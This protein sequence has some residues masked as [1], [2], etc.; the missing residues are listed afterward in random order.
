MSP[1]RGARAVG[2]AV[3][4]Q[5]RCPVCGRLRRLLSLTGKLARHAT[6]PG[7]PVCDGSYQ[8]PARVDRRGEA[9]TGGTVVGFRPGD[10]GPSAVGDPGESV[11]ETG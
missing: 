3:H 8:P 7:G 4:P 1:H 9:V 6:E 2:A 11:E 5:G 10:D